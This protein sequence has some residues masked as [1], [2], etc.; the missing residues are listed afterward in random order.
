MTILSSA[1]AIIKGRLGNFTSTSL[2]APIITEMAQAQTVMEE[3]DFKPWFLLTESSTALN[4]I[5]EERLP[6]PTDFI[7]E[8]EEG[9]L[10]WKEQTATV[11][12]DL[13]KEDYDFLRGRYDPTGSPKGYALAGENFL[14]VPEPIA[15]YNWKMRY[16]AKQPA[17]AN[18]TD[19]N[20]WLKYA[21]DWLIAETGLI[22]ANSY[23][24]DKKAADQFAA[25]K[26]E[27][28][29]RL[30]KHNVAKAEANRE[31]MMGE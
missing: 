20:V 15:I 18:P 27:A 13:T 22:I 25:Q 26:S 5:N 9:A 6:V 4:A 2:D 10:S 8:W 3:G 7:M 11:W 16:Y 31:R 24:R 14:I 17:N 21:S 1:Q 28:K 29:A 12:I 23:V 19:E 30:E